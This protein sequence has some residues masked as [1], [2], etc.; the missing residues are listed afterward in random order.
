MN[1]PS[2]SLRE[3]TLKA[4]YVLKP[5]PPIASMALLRISFEVNLASIYCSSGEAC[6]KNRSGIYIGL[7]LSPLSRRPNS[8]KYVRTCEPKPPMDPSSI[9]IKTSCS[10]ASLKIRSI[11][12]GFA[13]LASATVLERPRISNSS[14]A[15]KHSCSLPPNDKIAIFVPYLQYFSNFR[16]FNPDTW[17]TW[18]PKRRG[19][20][21]NR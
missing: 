9:V 20:I 14:A 5:S 21:F 4:F 15:F 7:T 3:S 16:H 11:S 17:T 12:K 10:L 2:K 13:N 1:Y 6:A 19:P 8:A 18:E